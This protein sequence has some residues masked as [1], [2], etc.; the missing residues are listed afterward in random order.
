MFFT[1][2]GELM[3]HIWSGTASEPTTAF[4][5]DLL[6]ID[7]DEGYPLISG[8]VSE[9]QMRGVLSIDVTGNV[10]ISLWH[11][12]S[13]SVVRTRAAVIVQASQSVYTSYENLWNSHL[14]SFGGQ[15]LIDFVADMAFSSS[16]YKTCLQVTQPEFMI[17]YNSRRHHQMMTSDVSRKITRINYPIGAKSC[18]LN[19]EN[20]RMCSLMSD[21]L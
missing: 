14:F 8:F 1:G 11:R 6:L 19:S 18:S 10:K 20:N 2:T 15:A 21:E 17:R 3:S 5:G 9:Q 13:H 16:P 4:N 12:N 7:H